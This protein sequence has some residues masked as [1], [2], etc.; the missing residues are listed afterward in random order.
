L[1]RLHPMVNAAMIG[2]E[3]LYVLAVWVGFAGSGYTDYLLVIASLF[4]FGAM[5]LP[6]VAL[7]VWRANRR[8]GVREERETFQEW[9]EGEFETAPGRV[10]SM[11]ATIEIL[12]P[13]AAVAFG[14][15]AFAIV[16]LMNR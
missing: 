6:L 16:A 10:S 11:T 7:R 13:I 8:P 14:M 12:L 15:T 3:L 2:L 9:A 4:V 5:A 1:R